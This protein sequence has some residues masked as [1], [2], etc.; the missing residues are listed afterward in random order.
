MQRGGEAIDEFRMRFKREPVKEAKKEKAEYNKRQE[1]LREQRKKYAES[2]RKK[3]GKKWHKSK[4]GRK[5]EK[6]KGFKPWRLSNKETL[7]EALTKCRIQIQ[8]SRDK[9][10][11]HQEE[12][13]KILFNK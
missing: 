6:V 2:M 5:P 12:R 11:E 1:R 4:R 7:V 10:T 13:A 3:H 8:K 9:W